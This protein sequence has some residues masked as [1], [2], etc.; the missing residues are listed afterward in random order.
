M[1]PIYRFSAVWRSGLRCPATA[2]VD[3]YN[4]SMR[5]TIAPERK[6]ELAADLQAHFRETHDETIGDLKAHLLLDFF[7]KT[8]GP[9][10]YNQG[11]KDA[12]AYFQA[13]VED[14]EAE[15]YQPEEGR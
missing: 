4:E 2:R 13:R 14:L 8:L 15:F 3:G 6:R 9:S 1:A 5:I 12:Q 7:V 10:F 11:I